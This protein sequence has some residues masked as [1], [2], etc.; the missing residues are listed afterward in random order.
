MTSAIIHIALLHETRENRVCQI[1]DLAAS[2]RTCASLV[3]ESLVQLQDT[4]VLALEEEAVL[5]SPEERLRIAELAIASGADPARVAKEL[6]W[7]EFESLADQLLVRDGFTTLI[8]FVFKAE[9]RRF[10]I[11]VVGAKETLVLCMDCKHWYH[12]WAPSKITAAARSQMLRVLCLSRVFQTYTRRLPIKNC[13]SVR[14]LP[15]VLTLAD[16]SSRLVEG[17]PIVSV[18][19]LRTFLSE[20]NPWVESLRFVDAR[21]SPLTLS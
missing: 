1:R 14:L 6:R 5:V 20:V 9:G 3:K 10:E 16:V 12:G 13:R 7:Q 8:H 18:F 21:M 15:I 17:V 2:M 4:G 11:D 19:R